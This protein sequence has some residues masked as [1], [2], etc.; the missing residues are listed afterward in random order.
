[1]PLKKYLKLELLELPTSLLPLS[2]AVCAIKCKILGIM[3]LPLKLFSA[4]QSFLSNVKVLLT[5]I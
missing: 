3:S 2:K 1:M 5:I 4:L